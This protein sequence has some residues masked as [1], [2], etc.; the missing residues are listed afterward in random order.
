MM[1]GKRKSLLQSIWLHVELWTYKCVICQTEE[2]AAEA[3]A[4]SKIFSTRLLQLLDIL[5]T[6][7]IKENLTLELSAAFP[8]DTSHC[9]GPLIGGQFSWIDHSF[10]KAY[11]TQERKYVGSQRRRI[12]NLLDFDVGNRAT[13]PEIREIKK[14]VINRRF[15][16]SLSSGALMTVFRC[17]PYLEEIVYEP[18]RTVDF[19]DDIAR[20]SAIK[21]LFRMLRRT[22]QKLELWEKKNFNKYTFFG[23]RDT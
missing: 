23:K 16:R 20:I 5:S 10:H 12:G 21:T 11:F 1:T 19:A 9:F 13:I 7:D 8:S 2:T 4:N 3:A 15:Q 6:C 18:S 14:F 17:L 22:V